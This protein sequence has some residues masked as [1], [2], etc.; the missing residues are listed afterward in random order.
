MYLADVEGAERLLQLINKFKSHR[1]A[2]E[3]YLK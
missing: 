3:A 1:L 2:F